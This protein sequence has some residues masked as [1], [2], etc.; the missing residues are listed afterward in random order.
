MTDLTYLDRS[1]K[2]HLMETNLP[3]ADRKQEK[4]RLEKRGKSAKVVRG[5]SRFGVVRDDKDS[6]EN[7]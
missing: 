6:N 7:I 1:G 5:E 4:E 3:E 2:F